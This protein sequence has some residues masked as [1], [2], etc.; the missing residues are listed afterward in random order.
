MTMNY[1]QL[2]IGNCHR[3]L[4]IIEIAPGVRIALFISLGD[5]EICAE[6]APLL[7]AK[8]PA[9]DIIITAETKGIAIAQE[10]A[11]VLQMDYFV[12]ARKTAKPYMNSTLQVDVNT[13]T[14]QKKQTLYLDDL[15]CKRLHGKRVIIVD[16]VISTGES[17]LALEKL[18]QCAGGNLVAKAAILAEGAAK[19]RQDI[20]YLDYLP[21][22]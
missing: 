11:R 7:A 22:Y 4:P 8:L 17:L 18:V 19:E 10:L 12:V 16:D 1:H 20:I 15:D 14:T 21:L 9:A 2:T 13:I 6:A 5:Y 3:Q